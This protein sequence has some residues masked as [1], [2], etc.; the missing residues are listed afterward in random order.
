MAVTI[1]WDVTM[2]AQSSI[3][4]G[5]ES[6]GIITLLRREK[7]LL[8]DGRITHIPIISGNS[9]R[10][11]LRRIGE[12]LLRDALRYDGQISLPAAH[13]LRGGGA[14]AKTTGPSL[15]GER[16][17]TLRRLNPHV[18]VFGCAAGGRI[19][20]GC[21]Q[22]GKIVP[23]YAETAHLLPQAAPG[24]N[25][26]P[27]F[28]LTQIETFA[29]QDDADTRGFPDT[30][31]AVPV[32]DEGFPEQTELDALELTSTAETPTTHLMQYRCETFPAGTRFSSWLSLTAASPHE[33]QYFADVLDA[34]R[35]QPLLGG[36]LRT[37]HG[38][39]LAD[40]EPVILRGQAEVA[41][42]R[43]FLAEHHDAAMQA[44]SYLT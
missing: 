12:D 23:H 7:I 36:R 24:P 29:R 14:L 41:D 10:G 28:D 17:R 38:L 6:R 3:A 35:A 40:L 42:W 5:G 22:V 44:L 32:D 34:W 33:L 43:A 39:V 30:A 27:H 19:I 26:L 16:L 4:H 11:K 18:A 20:D 2:T 1:R 9:W 31:R 25:T 15:S 8:P 21:L 13:A 37:G